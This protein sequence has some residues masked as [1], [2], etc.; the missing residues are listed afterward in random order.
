MAASVADGS[1][2]RPQSTRL[3][4]RIRRDVYAFGALM[5]TLSS[6]GAVPV[7]FDWDWELCRRSCQ[8]R[9]AQ[10]A[11]A[12]AYIALIGACIDRRAS[13]RPTFSQVLADLERIMKRSEER[14]L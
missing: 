2:R 6:A 7:D 1:A 4:N 12:A 9:G 5:W 14:M 10:P 13:R 8:A 3:V 11:C